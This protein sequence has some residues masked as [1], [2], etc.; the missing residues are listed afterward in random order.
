MSQ[1]LVS[2][3]KKPP[4]LPYF[5]VNI[6]P[7]PLRLNIFRLFVI[8]SLTQLY[9]YTP[10]IFLFSTATFKYSYRAPSD[11]LD[12]N[13]Q[14]TWLSENFSRWNG[15]SHF[16]S[17][18]NWFRKKRCFNNQMSVILSWTYFY[19]L[20]WN[21]YLYF[22]GLLYIWEEMI[23]VA[24]IWS[25]EFRM[26]MKNPAQTGSG[27]IRFNDWNFHQATFAVYSC[28]IR[29]RGAGRYI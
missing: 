14:R 3:K 21:D 19:N 11:E 16:R 20:H 9:R 8:L 27:C 5:K 26:H 1:A 7:S 13:S 4:P 6:C 28:P 23:M 24:L 18:L 17:G 2:L 29:L 15:Y 10:E 22:K 12:K 25:R